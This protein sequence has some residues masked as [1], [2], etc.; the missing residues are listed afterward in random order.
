MV[1]W[2]LCKTH[3]SLDP[4]TK[5][6]IERDRRRQLEV[7]QALRRALSERLLGAR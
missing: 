2:E 1:T 5:E 4:P 6:T 7:V 3:E